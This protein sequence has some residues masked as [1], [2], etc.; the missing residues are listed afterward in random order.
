FPYTA[1]FRSVRAFTDVGLWI[2]SLEFQDAIAE[3]DL[4]ELD[5]EKY[6]INTLVLRPIIGFQRTDFPQKR[7]DVLLALCDFCRRIIG[8]PIIPSVQS[9]VAAPDWI[10]LVSP[11]VVVLRHF[12]QGRDCCAYLLIFEG[13]LIYSR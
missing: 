9:G 11:G 7:S 4:F 10:I 13:V 1:L 6:C 5:T 2:R 3:I 12:V 8:Q